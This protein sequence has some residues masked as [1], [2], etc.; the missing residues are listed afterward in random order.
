MCEN[1]QRQ[2][3]GIWSIVASLVNKNPKLALKLA[4]TIMKGGSVLSSLDIEKFGSSK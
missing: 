4:L 2:Q 3:E 1:C